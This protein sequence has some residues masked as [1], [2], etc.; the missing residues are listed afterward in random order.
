MMEPNLREGHFIRHLGTLCGTAQAGLEDMYASLE[1]SDCGP[2]QAALRSDQQT[3]APQGPLAE[4]QPAS[5]SP[6][7]T[8][9][10]RKQAACEW[11]RLQAVFAWFQAQ[12]SGEDD[13][14]SAPKPSCKFD[15]HGRSHPDS[16]SFRC[17]VAPAE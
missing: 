9:D 16:S 5:E 14:R 12:V 10:L 2:S 7:G 13:S 17:I 6:A 3:V 15:L 1:K 8:M 4:V 11:Q